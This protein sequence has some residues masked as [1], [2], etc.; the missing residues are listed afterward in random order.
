MGDVLVLQRRVAV[1]PWRDT[2]DDAGQAGAGMSFNVAAVDLLFDRISSHAAGLGLFDYAVATHEPKNAPG[3]GVWCAVWIDTVNPMP[4]LSGLAATAGRVTFRMRI[5]AN[6]LAEPQ[7]S[8]DPN[9]LKAVTTMMA[10]YS[11][12][13]TLDG[14]ALAIDLLGM[15]GIALNAAAA[16]VTIT[17]RIYRVMEIQVPCLIDNMWTQAP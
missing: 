6:A 12:H 17:Q 8:I 1:L 2:V 15:Y 7:D 10:E 13:F 3:N 5:G 9:V 14:V 11:G 4:R 16:F